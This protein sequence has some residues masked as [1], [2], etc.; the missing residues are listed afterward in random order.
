RS[1][2]EKPEKIPRPRNAFIIYRTANSRKIARDLKARGKNGGILNQKVS[3]YAGEQWKAE[4]EEVKE[5]YRGY[6]RQEAEQHKRDYPDY[7][8]RPRR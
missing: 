6:A 3:Q 4:P 5:R 1:K 7:V 8:F 2:W